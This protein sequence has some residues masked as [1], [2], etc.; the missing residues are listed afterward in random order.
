MKNNSKIEI[1]DLS[2]KVAN[3]DLEDLSNTETVQIVGGSGYP[4]SAS[5]YRRAVN[6]IATG[7]NP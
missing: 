3:L 4:T 7:R 6:G 5:Y 1:T 2:H